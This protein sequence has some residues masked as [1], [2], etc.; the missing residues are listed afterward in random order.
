MVGSSA[1]FAALGAAAC[2]GAG[3]ALQHRSAVGAPARH[4]LR[5]RLLAHL[6]TRPQWILGSAFAGVGL[7]LH[8]LA[9]D[10]GQLAV[11]QPLLVT[12]LVF[13]LPVS[14]ALERR[15]IRVRELVWAAATIAGLTLFL[16]VARPGPP[17]HAVDLDDPGLVLLPVLALVGLAVIWSRYG[18]PWRRALSLGLAA[19]ACFGVLAA[20]VK[21]IVDQLAAGGPAVVATS[22]PLYTLL[23]VGGVGLVL[24]MSAFQAGPLGASLA[25]ITIT[26]PVVSVALGVSGFGERIAG[27]PGDI[28]AEVVG[29]L[30]MS[31]GVAATAQSAAGRGEAV[32][33]R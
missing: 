25:A 20:L 33:T 8:V 11:V 1:V 22:W 4:F 13:A 31:V 21:V 30:L 12:T 17:R 28:V 32:S 9:L 18:S 6:L 10:L 26:D 16:L 24:N 29:L 3:T 14:A 19:G 5:P 15:A 27:A 23:A 7:V 2:F